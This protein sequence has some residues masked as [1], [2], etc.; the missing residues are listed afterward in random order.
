MS[1]PTDSIT[2]LHVENDQAFAEMT[3]RFV[4]RYD[5]RM[6]VVSAEGA[7]AGL[8]YVETGD[9]DCI[10]SDYEMP[11]RDGLE[12]LKAIRRC[13]S[14]VPFILFTGTVEEMIAQSAL[15]GG[16]TAFLQKQTDPDQFE[17]LAGLIRECVTAE[18]S[19]LRPGRVTDSR[20]D[21]N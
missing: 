15:A 13:D 14:S 5:E 12:F 1:S 3:A 17:N 4:E 19:T 11:A 10:V 21:A 6:H 9:V 2:V 16:A 18:R 8:E 20:I 7:S